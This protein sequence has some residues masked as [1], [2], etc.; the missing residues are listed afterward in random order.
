M[1]AN[2][3]IISLP[4]AST[5]VSV[6]LNIIDKTQFRAAYQNYYRAM[7][8]PKIRWVVIPCNNG[9]NNM[10]ETMEG[11]NIKSA[12]SNEEGSGTT[13]TSELARITRSQTRKQQS[14]ETEVQ[15]KAKK[16]EKIRRRKEG[17]KVAAK[18]DVRQPPTTKPEQAALGEHWGM[19]IVDKK[20]QDARWLDGDLRIEIDQATGKHKISYQYGAATAAG[21]ALCGYDMVM[22]QEGGKF[23]TST[24]RYVPNDREDNKFEGDQGAAC[25]PWVFAMLRYILQ[26][27][28]FLTDRGGLR[29]AF[30]KKRKEKHVRKMAFDSK[31]ARIDMQTLVANELEKEETIEELPH[32]LSVP[33]LKAMVRTSPTSVPVLQ[34]VVKISPSEFFD[35]FRDTR[36]NDKDSNDKD[37][38]D[39]D[40]EGSDEEY[41]TALQLQLLMDAK[42][43]GKSGAA[44]RLDTVNYAEL[45]ETAAFRAIKDQVVAF[46]AMT[47]DQID[48]W[49]G[50]QPVDVLLTNDISIWE[51]K[52]ILQR[53]FGGFGELTKSDAA[54]FREGLLS[55]QSLGQVQII[56]ELEGF[57]DHVSSALGQAQYYPNYYLQEHGVLPTSPQTDWYWVNA[58]DEDLEATLRDNDGVR[59]H[60]NVGPNSNNYTYRAILS[61]SQDMS[62]SDAPDRDCV[63]FWI[64]DTNVFRKGMDFN[65]RADG[66]SEALLEPPQIRQRMQAR[67]E[68]NDNNIPDSGGDSPLS[69]LSETPSLPSDS[70]FDQGGGSNGNSKKRRRSLEGEDSENDEAGSKKPKTCKQSR[71]NNSGSSTDATNRSINK[72]S[73]PFTSNSKDR[74]TSLNRSSSAVH[75]VKQH[76][77]KISTARTT[78]IHLGSIRYTL[79]ARSSST[80]DKSRWPIGVTTLP[81]FAHLQG[82]DF[83]LWYKANPELKAHL[84]SRPGIPTPT[85]F[86]AL[87][88]MKF[89]NTFLYEPDEDFGNEW[90]KDGTVFDEPL[91]QWLRQI[92]GVGARNGEIRERMMRAYEPAVLEELLGRDGSLVGI[93]SR[94]EVVEVKGENTELRRSARARKPSRK[95]IS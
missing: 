12:S 83:G 41:N 80:T 31:Q 38:N 54:S 74:K 1:Q 91:V 34:A 22:R 55:N 88:H 42:N 84:N 76:P 85:T 46:A 36:D 10:A 47:E 18:S 67:Y 6:G 50:K 92:K 29:R 26:N 95:L 81:S 44:T 17:A 79:P 62:F 82:I 53:R 51:K 30:R 56:E 71:S 28:N 33:A 60:R 65:L 2:M 93:A 59:T 66:T 77:N 89:K 52:A 70:D 72:L 16:T 13:E 32:R 37:S 69:E 86:C 7:K 57:T 45:Q 68:V 24:L 4:A 11:Y 63:E 40:L 39:K 5:L 87:L 9:M 21:R 75:I 43:G 35:F 73:F 19:I 61:V 3:V 15:P 78:S 23:K 90:I 20:Q 64:N 8:S 49:V 48:Q 58:S 14:R 25:A 94:K 27:P